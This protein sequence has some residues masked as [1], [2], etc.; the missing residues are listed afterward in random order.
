M[1]VMG[2]ERVLP[3]CGRVDFFVYLFLVH[4]FAG[5]FFGG[6]IFLFFFWAVDIRH[7]L[8]IRRRKRYE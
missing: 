5:H 6:F 2:A 3:T 8:L 1:S 4:N 7:S